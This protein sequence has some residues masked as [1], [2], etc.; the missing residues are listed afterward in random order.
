MSAISS[1]RRQPVTERAR[2]L[3]ERKR[4]HTQQW[5]SMT[6]G[7]SDKERRQERV[8]VLDGYHTP[9]IAVEELLKREKFTGRSWECANGFSRITRVLRENGHRVLTSDIYRW[10]DTTMVVKDF[11]DF[12]RPPKPFRGQTFDIITNPPFVHAAMFAEKAMELLPT[13]GKLALILRLQFLEGKKRKAFFEQYPP[14]RIY[15][16]SYRLPRMHRFL[17]K[18]AKGGSTLA[19]AWFVWQKGYRGRPE[20]H[21][22]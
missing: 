9:R 18:G 10:H 12:R 16:F 13:G 22:I 8:R 4:R 17:W 5:A 2:R 7:S 15:V 1:R 19:F 3:P 21:W 14:K 6:V 11:A 20:I